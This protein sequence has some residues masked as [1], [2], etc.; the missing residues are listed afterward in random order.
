MSAVTIEV[1]ILMR[2][3][4]ANLDRHRFLLPHEPV[5]PPAR[6]GARTIVILFSV[7]LSWILNAAAVE[8][9]FTSPCAAWPAAGGVEWHPKPGGGYYPKPA[10][11]PVHCARK[12]KE[13]ASTSRTS[14]QA[15]SRLR[16]L[17]AAG[18]LGC[19]AWSP[20]S[21]L[22]DGALG[23][24]RSPAECLQR[25]M[26]DGFEGRI[27]LW[28][29][30]YALLFQE[31]ARGATVRLQ[32]FKQQAWRYRGGGWHH[33]LNASPGRKGRGERESRGH[34]KLTRRSVEMHLL[35]LVVDEV[36]TQWSVLP[37]WL[38]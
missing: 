37:Y 32:D 10:R 33:S 26:S 34:P 22:L 8:H 23:A 7:I 11:E 35:R 21:F 12:E 6:A 5:D 15:L 2:A 13:G 36:L 20:S 4:P 16:A 28:N 9:F 31:L 38:R 3:L 18:E 19:D 25:S 29:I 27:P 30:A 17:Q 24:A 1:V 14:Q